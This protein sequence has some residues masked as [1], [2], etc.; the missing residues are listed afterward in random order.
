MRTLRLN[1]AK[2]ARAAGVSAVTVANW[3]DNNMLYDKIWEYLGIDIASV[4]RQ[5]SVAHGVCKECGSHQRLVFC[6]K[7]FEAISKK[8]DI[9]KHIN[10]N[11][12]ESEYKCD[13]C[14]SEAHFEYVD[15]IEDDVSYFCS[16]CSK[17]RFGQDYSEFIKNSIYIGK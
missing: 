1:K 13:M 5:C 12:T 6:K 4:E 15:P 2:V 16:V 17:M 11:T 14:L 3:C 8:L 7:C 10:D 9:T